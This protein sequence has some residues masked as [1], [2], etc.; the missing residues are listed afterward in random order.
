MT[1]VSFTDVWIQANI[2]ENSI[3][4]IKIGDPVEITLDMAPGKVFQGKVFSRGFA[5]QQPSGGAA[6]EAVTI[7]SVLDRFFFM[8]RD[9]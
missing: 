7:K 9:T 1:F 5:I 6:G 4:N 3:G 8:K 2:R